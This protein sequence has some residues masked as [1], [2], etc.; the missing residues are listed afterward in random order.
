[1]TPVAPIGAVRS[2]A[3]RVPTD[4]AEADGTLS[5]D[6]TTPVTCEVEAGGETGFGYGYADRPTALF[7]TDACSTGS[8]G[9]WPHAQ[10]IGCGGLSRLACRA[11]VTAILR[12]RVWR[13]ELSP[14]RLRE[15]CETD[16]G[17]SS[18]VNSSALKVR[19][20]KRRKLPRGDRVAPRAHRG[21][22]GAINLTTPL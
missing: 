17:R 13:D 8:P 21:F 6:A 9:P 4:R 1:M 16:A 20:R 14:E 15:L 18:G 10:G 2:A 19:T 7:V 3:Y 22:R 11:D 5:W 12:G